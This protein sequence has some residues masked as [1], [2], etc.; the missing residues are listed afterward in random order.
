[1]NNT[2]EKEEEKEEEEIQPKAKISPLEIR[3]LNELQ[4]IQFLD[5]IIEDS[6][7]F[8]YNK[9]VKYFQ[10]DMENFIENSESDLKDIWRDNKKELENILNFS[11]EFAKQNGIKRSL[12]KETLIYSIPIYAIVIGF[13]FTVYLFP[14][15]FS[16]PQ[17]LM[18]IFLFIPFLFLCITNSLVSRMVINKRMKFRD[19]K[20][21]ILK[22]QMKE[23][24]ES[25]RNVN[26]VI[27]NDIK[28]IILENEFETS[29]FKA[30]LYNKNYNNLK[31]LE[32]KEQHKIPIYLIG[33]D[34][35]D[36]NP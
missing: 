6:L 36:Q 16:I 12:Q 3:I 4:I 11:E 10:R 1:M 2:E 13:T 7:L 29:K 31:V 24:I 15:L 23:S 17:D 25:I 34:L 27:I 19:K 26:Q 8:I 33:I 35:A 21:P 5:N 28:D 32:I 14:Q 20:S 22:E 9:T 18:M 30:Y